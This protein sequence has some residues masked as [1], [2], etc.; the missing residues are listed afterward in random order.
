MVVVLGVAGSIVR[1]LI[2]M[3]LGYRPKHARAS[4]N[5]ASVDPSEKNDRRAEELAKPEDLVAKCL[6]I[7]DTLVN[8]KN[9]LAFHRLS[10]NQRHQYDRAFAGMEVLI[11]EVSTAQ[12]ESA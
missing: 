8:V 1:V 12:R 7:E 9:T 4:L 3:Y 10:E 2:P 5:M 11:E 6:R